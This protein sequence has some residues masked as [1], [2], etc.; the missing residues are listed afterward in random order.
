MIRL[1]NRTVFSLLPE[2]LGASSIYNRK[3]FYI[4]IRVWRF[5]HFLI[6]IEMHFV[7]LLDLVLKAEG[8]ILMAEHSIL[9]AVQGGGVA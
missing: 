5:A 9:L 6:L 2:L 8:S 7:S 3:V 1:S 4:C